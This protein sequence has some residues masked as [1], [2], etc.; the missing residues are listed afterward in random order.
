MAR[1]PRSG[2]TKLF[3]FGPIPRFT[4]TKANKVLHWPMYRDFYQLA[5]RKISNILGDF[6]ESGFISTRVSW[7][8][9]FETIETLADCLSSDSIHW[10]PRGL[11]MVGAFVSKLV[12]GETR[13][14][15]RL[16]AQSVKSALLS[17]IEEVCR[18]EL[19]F[20]E[21]EGNYF[22]YSLHL[23]H[24]N[25]RYTA[26]NSLFS[27]Q[28]V[29]NCFDCASILHSPKT[30]CILFQE[31][32]LPVGTP[33][34]L[35][36]IYSTL[37]INHRSTYLKLLCKLFFAAWTGSHLATFQITCPHA[38]DDR[39]KYE[40]NCTLNMNVLIQSGCSNESIEEIRMEDYN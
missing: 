34:F 29:C 36:D 12:H 18:G 5:D 10:N 9:I 3:V 13:E 20:K 27:Y 7:C 1:S 21:F 24:P 31:T 6:S 33:C 32:R 11:N 28:Y 39:G 2:D 30:Y 17:D 16:M 22:N 8:S 25:L 26:H 15:S 38:C 23:P 4:G 14:E 37:V 35:R 19:D 40:L